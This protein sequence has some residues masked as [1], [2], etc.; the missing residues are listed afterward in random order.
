MMEEFK[1][2]EIICHCCYK[3]AI[4]VGKAN[5]CIEC[6]EAIIYEQNKNRE[7]F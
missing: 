3:R 1:P 2:H 5:V 7:Q 4:V 6:I